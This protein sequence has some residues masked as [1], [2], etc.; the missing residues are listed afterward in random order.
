MNRRTFLAAL[1]GTPTLAAL[2][3]ACGDDRK[4]SSTSN[5]PPDVILKIT[6]EG[7]FVPAGFAF[8]NLPSLL[9]SGD[10]RAFTPGPMIEIYPGPLLPAISERTINDAGIK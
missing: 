4:Y 2:V 8:V 10:G 3:A 5:P 1:A 7:G 6:Y 9:I